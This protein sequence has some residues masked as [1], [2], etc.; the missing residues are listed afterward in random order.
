MWSQTVCWGRHCDS[1]S[2]K[3]LPWCWYSA[4]TL[5]FGVDDV[6]GLWK[7]THPMKYWFA[8]TSLGTFLV[9]GVKTAPFA[10]GVQKMIGS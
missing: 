6:V 8:T 3:T 5:G 10:F 4:G 9:R 7:V 1:S 2:L